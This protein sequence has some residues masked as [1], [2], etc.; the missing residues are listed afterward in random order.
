M[1]KEK[2]KK[3]KGK[4]NYD[5]RRQNFFSPTRNHMADGSSFASGPSCDMQVSVSEV[6]S[7][8]LIT[9]LSDSSSGVLL[10]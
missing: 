9:G 2:I 4:K 7:G 6:Q 1:K 3:T 5:S 10:G 8:G